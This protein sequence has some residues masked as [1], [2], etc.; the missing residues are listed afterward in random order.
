MRLGPAFF[1]RHTLRVARDLVGM[2]LVRHRGRTVRAYRIV[3]TEAYHGPRDRASHASR[4]MTPRTQ[5]MFGPPGHTYVYLVYGMHHCLNFSTMPAGFPAAVLIRAV[6]HPQGNGPGRVCRLLGITRRQNAL[7]PDNGQLW[8]EDRGT[9][10][11]HVVASPRIG[12]AYAGAWSRKRWR[13]T[14]VQ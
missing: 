6:V 2:W 7:A 5:V 10:P 8:I 9:R 12:V 3:E 1:K 13:F 14:L 11:G 4:G